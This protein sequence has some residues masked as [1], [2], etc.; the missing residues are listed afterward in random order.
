MIERSPVPIQIKDFKIIY[1]LTEYVEAA[2]LAKVPKEY[3]EQII[4]RAKILAVFSKD[5]DRQV[6]GG[7]VQEGMLEPARPSGS[8]AA[9]PRS[10]AA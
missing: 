3:I 9:K 10:V 5:K 7:K 2:M 6:V 1:E 4:G 8:C